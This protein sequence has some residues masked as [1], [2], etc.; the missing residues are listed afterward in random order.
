MVAEAVLTQH[1]QR[2]AVEGT[3]FW[4]VQPQL[5]FTGSAHL[6]TLI[7][8]QYFQ[9]QPGAGPTRYEFQAALEPAAAPPPSEGLNLVLVAPRLSS[10][11]QG[12]RIYYRDIVVGEVTGYE[13]GPNA[14]EVLVYANIEPDYATLVREGTRFWNASGVNIDVGL[15]SGASIKTESLEAILA[16]GIGFATP[17]AGQTLSPV[18]DGTRFI[19]HAEAE[20]EWLNWA[21]QIP[22]P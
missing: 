12:L 19:L 4:L 2:F 15:F 18:P 10:I 17:D 6:E 5:G 8:G 3:R 14:N 13:L 16:G 1:P 11:R 21:P 22:L 9:V 20:P 7:K